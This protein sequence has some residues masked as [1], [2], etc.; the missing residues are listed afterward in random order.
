MNF[1]A[2]N[3]IFA[4]KV[5]VNFAGSQTQGSRL[6]GLVSFLVQVIFVVQLS[7]LTQQLVLY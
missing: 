2:H 7:L 4:T 1:L 5:S 6:G 3:D